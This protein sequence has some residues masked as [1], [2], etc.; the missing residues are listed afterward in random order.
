M[1]LHLSAGILRAIFLAM[2]LVLATLGF[3]AKLSAP[4]GTSNVDR[5][6]AGIGFI[7][8]GLNNSS[9]KLLHGREGTNCLPSFLD[10]TTT[11]SFQ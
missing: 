11:L 8:P 9:C 7:D 3:R 2:L 10:Q 1:Y 5:V 4:I 6:A